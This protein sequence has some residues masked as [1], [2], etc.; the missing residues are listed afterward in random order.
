M[1]LQ[2]YTHG[3]ELAPTPSTRVGRDWLIQAA[4]SRSVPSESDAVAGGL[5]ALSQFFIDEE[6]LGETVSTHLLGVYRIP[7]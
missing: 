4:T 7:R 5:R 1:L 6:T 2:G 3:A